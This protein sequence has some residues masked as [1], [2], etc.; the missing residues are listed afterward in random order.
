MTRDIIKEGWNSA[1]QLYESLK[2][3]DVEEHRAVNGRERNTYVSRECGFR[4]SWPNGWSINT[5]NAPFY[6]R[7]LGMDE[8]GKLPVVILPDSL[9]G[10]FRPAVTVMVQDGVV[11]DIESYIED[12]VKESADG[13]IEVIRSMDAD[14]ATI[15]T[16]FNLRPFNGPS[17]ER[18][19]RF[20]KVALAH[21]RVY[22]VTALSIAEHAIMTGNK[23]KSDI[24]A[25]LNSFALVKF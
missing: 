7:Q 5:S 3:H 6:K 13:L 1:L 16:F 24:E 2:T 12:N 19:F 17:H 4:I 8:A 20:H 22:I 23:L 14:R 15:L 11:L 21:N 25:T 10:G 18:I 9:C